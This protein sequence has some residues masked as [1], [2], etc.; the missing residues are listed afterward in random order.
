MRARRRLAFTVALVG[1]ALAAGVR[2]DRPATEV[3]ARRAGPLSRFLVVDG[4]RTHY[5]DRGAGPTIVLLHG[6]NSS[7][8]AWE[9]WTPELTT[10]HRVI[11]LDL[12]GHGL[13]GP[14]LRARYQAD[15][16]AEFV[17]RFAVALGLDHFVLIGNSMGGNVAWRY[18]LAHPERIDRLILVDAAGLPREEP[19]PFGFR[20]FASP[21]IGDL[22]RWFSPRFLIAR[23]LRDTYG[24]PA[25]V[26]DAQI[27]L[28]EDL[29]LRAGNR[30]ATRA[31]FAGFVEDGA[32][33]R[34]PELHTPTLILWG[35]RDRWILPK[36][37]ERLHAA[38]PGSELVVLD[39]VGHV[40]MEEDPAR[41][42]AAVRA[43]LRP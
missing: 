1:M 3:E 2:R 15:Q 6:S 34:L 4:L 9:G 40:S 29:L 18:A 41:S 13:T 25:R 16:M 39:G 11:A 20:M 43:F 14:D 17:E 28:Y 27:D 35:S 37:G 33:S 21:V 7:L 8:F 5:R 12:P 30:E 38:I 26:T 19:R 24:D 10:D 23:S 31:R 42:V 22:A 36:Y 32:H